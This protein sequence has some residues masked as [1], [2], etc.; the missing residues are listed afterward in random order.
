[1]VKRGCHL[2]H[3]VS[4]GTGA[5]RRVKMRGLNNNKSLMSFFPVGHYISTRNINVFIY[6]PV[7]IILEP[8]IFMPFPVL[9]IISSN[10]ETDDD[11]TIK[12]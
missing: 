5:R 3:E 10:T 12:P 11:C 7:I 8:G 2:L 6:V 9:L 4:R 1:M